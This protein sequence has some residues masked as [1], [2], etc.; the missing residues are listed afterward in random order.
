MSRLLAAAALVLLFLAVVVLFA[1]FDNGV[2]VFNQP[3]LP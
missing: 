1:F 2:L 3:P